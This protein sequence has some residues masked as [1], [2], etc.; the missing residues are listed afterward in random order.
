MLVD[1]QQAL[2][3]LTASPELCIE[4]RR[5]PAILRERY[6]LTE[7][8]WTRVTGIVNHPGMQCNCML[9]RA[10]RLAPLALNVP[11]TCKALGKNLRDV[12]SEF[13]K[14]YPETNVHFFI[15]TDR[16]CRFLKAKL[17]EDPSFEVDVA[18]VLDYESAIITAA[19]AQSYI[20]GL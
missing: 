12:V 3:D 14:E 15:E 13:W 10:N 16:F 20:E 2:A 18:S 17:A 9:Y 6:Q 7:K 19:L 4:V 5:D 11:G 8:E 1:F